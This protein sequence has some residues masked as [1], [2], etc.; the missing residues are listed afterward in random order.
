MYCRKSKKINLY[1]VPIRKETRL[2]QLIFNYVKEDCTILLDKYSAYSNI[3]S[4]K[5]TLKELTVTMII[6]R[7]IT[8]RILL[9]NIGL[10]FEGILLKGYEESSIIKYIQFEEVFLQI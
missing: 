3:K 8:Q 9:I 10:I 2:L 5:S 1:Y 7:P 4:N 6:I